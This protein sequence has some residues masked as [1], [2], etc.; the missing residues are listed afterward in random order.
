MGCK[1]ATYEGN[2]NR[3][4]VFD[5]AT[6]PARFVDSR[7][8]VMRYQQRKATLVICTSRL[9]NHSLT[10]WEENCRRG[11]LRP[12]GRTISWMLK[13]FAAKVYTI[14]LCNRKFLIVVKLTLVY[15]NGRRL[16][17]RAAKLDFAVCFR[18]AK[19]SF[20]TKNTSSLLSRQS[21]SCVITKMFCMRDKI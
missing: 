7:L 12:R 8:L 18:Y 9:R 15:F 3:R 10:Y 2:L 21:K 6:L 16:K 14:F 20:R 5:A 11:R 1:H 4:C 13:D 19:C 17:T